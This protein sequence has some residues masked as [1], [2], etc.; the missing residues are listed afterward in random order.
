MEKI[1]TLLYPQY[2]PKAC[3]FSYDDGVLQDVWVVNLFRQ[4][5]L[6]G[7]FNLNSGQFGQPKMRDGIDCSHLK[8]ERIVKLYEGQEIATHTFSHPH[9]ENLSKAEQLNEYRQDILKLRELFGKPIVGSAYPFGTYNQTTL[10]VLDE[11]NVKYARTTKST[12]DFHRP[13]NF[14]LW[15]PTIHHND[16]KIGDIVNRF[17]QTSEELAI[18]YIWGHS[19]EFALQNNWR[20]FE[21]LCADLACHPHIWFATNGEIYEYIKA[22]ELSY[23]RNNILFNPSNKVIFYQIGQSVLSLEPCGQRDIG[24]FL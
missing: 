8:E 18:L 17:Y 4:Y 2:K 20:E 13:Y 12:Y 11:L 15:H 19:Y 14:R 23:V 24:E 1:F 7:T 6:K 9:L 5:N 10:D 21:M 3:T 16:L 22:A